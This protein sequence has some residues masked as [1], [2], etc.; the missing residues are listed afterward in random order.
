MAMVERMCAAKLKVLGGVPTGEAGEKLVSISCGKCNTFQTVIMN[1][2]KI[3]KEM[4]ER[5][6]R[7]DMFLYRRRW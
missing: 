6:P 2:E 4:A 5:C 1:T 3:Q 7:L